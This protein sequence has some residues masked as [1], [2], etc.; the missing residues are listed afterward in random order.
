VGAG[1]KARGNGDRTLTVGLFGRLGSG[2]IGNDACLEAVVDYVRSI[3]PHAKLACMC[4]GPENVHRWHDIPARQLHWLH[5]KKTYPPIL[6][7]A[8]F[9]GLF[10]GVG[11]AVDTRRTIAWARRQDVVIVPGMGVL[12]ANLPQRPWQVPYSLFLLTAAAKISKTKVAFVGVGATPVPQRLTRWLLRS[13][14]RMADYRSFR[15]DQSFDTARQGGMAQPYDEVYTDLAYAF[16][17]PPAASTSPPVADKDTTR[18]VGVGVMAYSGSP[19]DRAVADAIHTEYTQKMTSFVGRLVRSGYRVRLLVSDAADETV[20]LKILDKFASGAGSARA[21]VSYERPSSFRDLLH[22]IAAVEAVVATRYH[23]VLG[24]LINGIPTLAVG[25]GNKHHAA[26]L[27]NGVPQYAQD[28]LSLDVDLLEKQFNDL[29]ERRAEVARTIADHRPHVLDLLDRQYT[30]MRA[31][32]FE[33]PLHQ[34]QI[35]DET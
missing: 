21:S 11:I 34:P 26:M 4:S 33:P 18:T 12:E 31:A 10:V 29:Y 28:A 35:P 23:C 3:F 2:N 25:Y 6:P 22:Q 19:T 17:P 5:T 15:D 32:L 30:A 27:A 24:G 16:S 9:A 7:R 13:A 8:V 14:A 20:A 1:R